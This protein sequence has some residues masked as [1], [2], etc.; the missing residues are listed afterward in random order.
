MTNLSETPSRREGS[1]PATAQHVHD[2]EQTK[3]QRQEGNYPKN[4]DEHH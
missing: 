3:D 4:L 2:S 1:H